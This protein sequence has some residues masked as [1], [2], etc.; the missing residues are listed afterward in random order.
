MD[1]LLRKFETLRGHV[2]APMRDDYEG[3]SAVGVIAYGTTH[4]S[5]LEA[6]AKLQREKGITFD[7]LRLLAFPFTDDVER[8]V[9]EHDRVYVIEQNRDG[10]M[11]AMLRHE[12]PRVA[13]KLRSIRHYDGMPVPARFIIN[14]VVEQ[15]ASA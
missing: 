12:L 13:A 10:Q 15:E 8:F 2:P 3:G 7:Y 9:E 6:R 5:L 14:Q 1:R 4:W 11:L